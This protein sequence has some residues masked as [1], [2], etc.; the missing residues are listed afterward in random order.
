[1]GAI[2]SIK[3]SRNLKWIVFTLIDA[4][5]KREFIYKISPEGRIFWHRRASIEGLKP[6]HKVEDVSEDGIGL[7]CSFSS[8][9]HSYVLFTVGKGQK[10]FTPLHCEV[11]FAKWLGKGRF[12][13]SGWANGKTFGWIWNQNWKKVF[14]IEG[15]VEGIWRRNGGIYIAVS[16]PSKRGKRFSYGRSFRQGNFWLNG[17]KKESILTYM[18]VQCP[19]MGKWCC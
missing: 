7:V 2:S 8:F 14:E 18:Y 15:Y 16:K 10:L 4:K 17:K 11:L 13:V 9:F 6:I 12:V 19:P 5:Y 3:A 1:M